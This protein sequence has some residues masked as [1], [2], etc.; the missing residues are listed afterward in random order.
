MA[1]DLAIAPTPQHRFTTTDTEQQLVVDL[2]TLQ[3]LTGVELD[4]GQTEIRLCLPDGSKTSIPLPE[5]V[6]ARCEA[7]SGAAKFS[8]KRAQLTISW[9]LSVLP[10]N[11]E[12]ALR[13]LKPANMDALTYEAA[14]FSSGNAVESIEAP[15]ERVDNTLEDLAADTADSAEMSTPSAYDD[16]LRTDIDTGGHP[17]K[18]AAAKPAAAHGSLWNANSWHWEE[19]NCLDLVRTQVNQALVQCMSERLR[20]IN[21]LSGASIIISATAVEGEASFTLRRGKRILC[22]ELSAKFNWEARDAYGGPLGAKGKAEVAELTQDEEAPQ[23]SVEVFV[24]FSGGKEGKAAGEWMKR[25]GSKC[26]SKALGGECLVASVLAAEEARVSTDKDAARRAE[27][28]A[29]AEDALKTTAEQ[30]ERLASEQ[31]QQEEARR[32]KP[33][34]GAVQ[35]SV[36]NANAWHWEEKPMTTWAHAWLQRKLDGLTASM[37]GGLAS[38]SLSDVKVSGDAS[39]SVRKG[40]PITLFQLRLEC[41]WVVKAADAGIGEA[42]GTLLVPEFT[43][44]DGDKSAIEVQA[45]THVKKSSSQ[46]LAGVRRDGLPAVR[47]VLAEFIN[48]LKGQLDRS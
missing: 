8:R 7:N 35:G 3:S 30:R 46:L 37:L 5:G 2:P 26:I 33:V 22:Y 16:S 4:I 23:V 28:R 19:K 18:S 13:V 29:K 9:Q 27:E 48:E 36:W 38:V 24:S 1:I 39:L 10:T 45:A 21:E 34:E 14:V 40:R 11:V 12:E 42:Q 44:E 6:S 41:K 47:S 20:H 43:S 25:H 17:A 31:K 32:V 15:A